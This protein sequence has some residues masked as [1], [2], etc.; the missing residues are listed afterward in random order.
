MCD[1]WRRPVGAG[2]LAWML[3]FARKSNRS[4]HLQRE[5]PKRTVWLQFNTENGTA[6]TQDASSLALCCGVSPRGQASSGRSR[7]AARSRASAVP[8]WP[9]RT[10]ARCGPAAGPPGSGAIRGLTRHDHE[11]SVHLRQARR[12]CLAACCLDDP[13]A[14]HAS[15]PCAQAGMTR[16]GRLTSSGAGVRSSLRRRLCGPGT[17]RAS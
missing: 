5:Q 6:T 12:A 4:N 14:P 8:S 7:P 10:A 13:T 16:P 17:Q 1:H 11:P 15:W 9:Q 3:L 2:L